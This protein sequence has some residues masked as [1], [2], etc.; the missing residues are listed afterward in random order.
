MKKTI[1]KIFSPWGIAPLLAA[2]FCNFLVYL[3][4]N[5]LTENWTLHSLALPVDAQI[6]LIPCT[7]VIYFGCYLFWIVNYILIYRRSREYA[8]RFFVADFLARV[9]CLL[10]YL[11][12]PTTL[13]RPVVEGTGF[14]EEAIRFL[15]QIDAPTNLFPSIHCLVSWFCFIGILGDKKIPV[16]YKAASFFMAAAVFVS[17]LTTRQHVILDI[18]GGVVFAQ[19]CFWIAQRTNLWKITE[20]TFDRLNQRIIGKD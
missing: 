17:T 10:F 12:Y 14:F 18:V 20:K 16:W 5:R 11:L 9:V 19:L 6:P 15:Y 1:V 4:C 8:Y 2:V 13:E 7:I 3:G